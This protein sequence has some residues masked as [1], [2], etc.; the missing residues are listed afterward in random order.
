VI[1]PNPSEFKIVLPQEYHEVSSI[2]L[3][4]GSVPNQNNVILD[5]YLLMSIEGLDH[6]KSSSGR[7]YFSTLSLHKGHSD[8]FFNM[9]RSS[10]S[11]MPHHFYSPKQRV[12]SLNIKLFHAD[13][14]AL[15]FGSAGSLVTADQTSFVFEVRTLANKRIVFDNNF[16]GVF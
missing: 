11:I 3:V 8:I 9:D 13:G 2:E 14:S 1:F 16:R 7:D 10:A 4:S 15:T 6:L 5:P 12:N